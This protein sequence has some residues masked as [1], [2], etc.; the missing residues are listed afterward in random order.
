VT[1]MPHGSTIACASSIVAGSR[2]EVFVD[3]VFS[4]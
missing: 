2:V 3:F 1:R 4:G